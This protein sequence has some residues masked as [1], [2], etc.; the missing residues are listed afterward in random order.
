MVWRSLDN[1]I[2]H[3]LSL[4]VPSLSKK[5]NSL[6]GKA[7]WYTA[8]DTLI[9]VF[10][11]YLYFECSK[12]KVHLKCPQTAGSTYNPSVKI[13]TLNKHVPTPFL[14]SR[15]YGF[16]WCFAPLGVFFWGFPTSVKTSAAP[17]VAKMVELQQETWSSHFNYR[18]V[19]SY[20]EHGTQIRAADL[21][22]MGALGTLPLIAGGAAM[23]L[24]VVRNHS[25]SHE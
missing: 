18:V 25:G 4:P 7:F 3:F 16:T 6:T 2:F 5:D 22:P 21:S 1:L 20:L 8:H 11:G 12:F 23:M 10:P 13:V 24:T 15:G 19:Y 9:C 17:Q 14:L